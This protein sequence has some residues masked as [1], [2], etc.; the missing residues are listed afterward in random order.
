MFITPKEPFNINFI[1]IDFLKIY[2]MHY[3]KVMYSLN[4]LDDVSNY[5]LEIVKLFS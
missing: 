4:E 5:D 2:F 3:F 1:F